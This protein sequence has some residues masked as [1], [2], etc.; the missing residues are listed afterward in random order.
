VIE[1]LTDEE[2]DWPSD[3][4]AL[5]RLLGDEELARRVEQPLPT[6][7]ECNVPPAIWHLMAVLEARKRGDDPH[8]M[9]VRVGI[10]ARCGYTLT[11]EAIAGVLAVAGDSEDSAGRP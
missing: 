11:R 2:E 7:V 8:P 9:A 3:L 1:A 5:R 4:D 6:D 10:V